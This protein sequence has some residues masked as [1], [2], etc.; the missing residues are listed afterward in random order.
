MAKY[1]NSMTSEVVDAYNFDDKDVPDFVKPYLKQGMVAVTNLDPTKP[2]HKLVS[3][4]Q[5]AVFDKESVLLK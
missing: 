1:K 2:G 3:V 4:Y 5:K